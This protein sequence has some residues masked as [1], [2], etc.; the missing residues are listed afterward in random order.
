ML[1]LG[2]QY[3]PAEYL[4]AMRPGDRLIYT[5]QHPLKGAR[6]GMLYID[7]HWPLDDACCRIPGYPIPILPASGVAQATIYWSIVADA[8]E[9]QP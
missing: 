7:P 8:V 5:T 6:P 9:H 4:Q 2:Y 3:P 1:L